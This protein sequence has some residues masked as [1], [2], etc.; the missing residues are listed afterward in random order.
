MTQKAL[1]GSNKQQFPSDTNET[2]F[3]SEKTKLFVK[4][5]PSGKVY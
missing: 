3:S 2:F 1:K 4:Q 5:N